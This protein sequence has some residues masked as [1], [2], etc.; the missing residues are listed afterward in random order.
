MQPTTEG[1]G[2]SGP[3]QERV[4]HRTNHPPTPALTAL[5]SACAAQYGHKRPITT[6]LDVNE[7]VEAQVKFMQG[8]HRF[9]FWR[10]QKLSFAQDASSSPQLCFPRWDRHRENGRAEQ[11]R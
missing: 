4:S 11:L 8:D 3:A 6:G 7:D 1:R 10:E 2:W 5:L 9:R